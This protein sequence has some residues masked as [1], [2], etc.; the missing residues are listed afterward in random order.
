MHE[1]RDLSLH[2]C[3]QCLIV[4]NLSIPYIQLVP[5]CSG[6]NEKIDYPEEYQRADTATGN[7][8]LHRRVV[9]VHGPKCGHQQ[10]KL[11]DAIIRSGSVKTV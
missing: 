6:D 7:V 8:E 9:D 4:T 1:S 5:R 2:P 11:C 10:Q 3:A